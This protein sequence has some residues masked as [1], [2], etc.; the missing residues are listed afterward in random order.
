MQVSGILTTDKVF[1]EIQSSGQR[2]IPIIIF[3]ISTSCFDR[4]EFIGNFYLPPAAILG[5]YSRSKSYRRSFV[6][7]K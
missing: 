5:Y 1:I 6:L 4:L 2:P 7:L 3:A